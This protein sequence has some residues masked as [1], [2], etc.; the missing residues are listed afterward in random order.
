MGSDQEG[1]GTMREFSR[2]KNMKD[3]QIF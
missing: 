2:M 3:Q 1:G